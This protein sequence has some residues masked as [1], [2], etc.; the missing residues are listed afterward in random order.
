MADPGSISS[1][2]LGGP[3]LN[4]SQLSATADVLPL[5]RGTEEGQIS[6]QALYSAVAGSVPSWVE[7]LR[8]PSGDLPLAVSLFDSAQYWRTDLGVCT[9][10]DLWEQVDPAF[11]VYNPA[12]DIIPGVGLIPFSGEGG[13]TYTAPVST[14][15]MSALIM[16]AATALYLMTM[17]LTGDGNAISINPQT[18]N[19]PDYTNG[20]SCSARFEADVNGN[21]GVQS[22]NSTGTFNAADGIPTTGTCSMAETYDNTT[23][24]VSYNG[25]AII[26]VA[27]ASYVVQPDSLG[28][29][30]NS[31]KNA[32]RGAVFYVPQPD[33]DLPAICALPV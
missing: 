13:Y 29:V 2:W 1:R 19:R 8:A 10:Q 32:A 16:P 31:A 30:V 21:P 23:T 22:Y 25:A 11:G 27:S 18:W 28:L 17:N 20:T 9:V 7:A 26:S 33:A 6:P 14:V 12:T 4:A 5:F 24:R 3:T 15:E